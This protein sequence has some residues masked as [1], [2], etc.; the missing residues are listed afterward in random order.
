MPIHRRSLLGR[1]PPYRRYGPRAGYSSI[2]TAVAISYV[3]LPIGS[4]I[5]TDKIVILRM[6]R[7]RASVGERLSQ[8]S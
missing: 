1:Y 8:S 4:D 3:G 6:H 5:T 7:Q 2:R